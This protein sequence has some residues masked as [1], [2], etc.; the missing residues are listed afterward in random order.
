MDVTLNTSQPTQGTNNSTA[1]QAG[2]AAA[3][4]E[5]QKADATAQRVVAGTEKQSLENNADNADQ[6]RFD[7]IRRAAAQFSKGDNSFLND[8]KYT[9]YN[10]GG[11]STYEI[12]FTDVN[13]GTIDVKSEAQLLG[14]QNAG[15]IVSGSI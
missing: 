6:K 13:T 7:V 14:T 9:V 12:R 10:G 5:G 8:V 3:Q 11:E 1:G 15:N 2:S 4:T